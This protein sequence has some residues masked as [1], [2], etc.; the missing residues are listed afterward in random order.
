ME[1]LLT[2]AAVATLV[3]VLGLPIVLW[4]LVIVGALSPSFCAF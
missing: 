3:A 2:V 4:M 1:R